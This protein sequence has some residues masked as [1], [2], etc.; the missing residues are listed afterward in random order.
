[1]TT[2]HEKTGILLINTGSPASPD[3]RDIKPYLLE[4]LS[5]RN[6]IKVPRPIWMP[7]L[8]GIIC[9]TRPQKTAPRYAQIWTSEG[10]PLLVHSYAQRDALNQRFAV[11]QVPLL[12]EVGM[13]YGSPS[14]DEAMTVLESQGCRQIIAL[15]LF[16]QTTF[17]TVKTCKEKT[18]EVACHHPQ[19]TVEI[20]EGYA[21]NSFYL[22]ALVA[23]ITEAWSYQP[24]SKLLLVFHSVP[25][26]DIKAG[27]TY[28]EQIEHTAA[29]VVERLAI[30]QEDW[31]IAY[32]SRFEDSRA[33]V[34]PHPKKILTQW[35][36]EHVNRVAVIT[37]GFASDCLES[38]YDIDITER[39]Y[40]TQLCR[41]QGMEADFTY[42]PA[43]N[44]RPD[45]IEA[46]YHVIMQR[47]QALN[48]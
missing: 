26:S 39:E 27:D 12:A 42:I 44:S 22:D 3:P 29:G 13:R 36:H 34:A 17:S 19:S 48:S 8:K 43:L 2:T 41:E 47:Y 15:P 16:P 18:L 40:F 46:L 21:T 9:R 24:G 11:D 38:L 37:P 4:F 33:W 25:L 35:S 20:I 23:S 32:H 30:P 31:A 7:I 45:H 1:M 6:L 5:D 14:I 10:A 28:L